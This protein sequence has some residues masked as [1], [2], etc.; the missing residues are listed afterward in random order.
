MANNIT[1][2]LD[3]LSRGPPE[4]DAAALRFDIKRDLIG[5][6][7]FG[8]VYK[9]SI[10]GTDVA[11]K[12][13][14]DQLEG[15]STSELEEVRQ[16]IRMLRKIFHP[17]VVLLVRDRELASALKTCTKTHAIAAGRVHVAR[18]NPH[19]VRAHED[20]CQVAH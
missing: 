20:E 15:S 12:I 1:H 13:P 5:E 14:N 9:G 11:I 4:I 10:G 6:G 18:K 8:K 7:A 17:N 19:C 16:E 2:W 3:I